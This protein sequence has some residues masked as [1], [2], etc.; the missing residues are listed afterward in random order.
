[1]AARPFKKDRGSAKVQSLAE[2]AVQALHRVDIVFTH[3]AL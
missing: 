2:Q 1:M 3:F